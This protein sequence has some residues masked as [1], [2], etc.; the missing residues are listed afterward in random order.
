MSQARKQIRLNAFDM[1]CVGHISHGMWT[2]PRDRSAHYTDI[3]YWQHLART[4]ER[5]LFDGLFIADIIGLYDVYKG[6]PETA[7][8]TGAQ[9]PLNDPILL[10]PIMAAVTEHLGFG[11][12]VNLTYEQPYLFARRFS[13]LDHLTRG[14][15]GWNIVTGY[16]DSAARGL[17]QDKLQNHDGRYD[18]ADEFMEVVYKLWEGSWEDDAVLRDRERRIFTDPSKV[19]RISHRGPHY[20]VD[21]I[22]LSEPSPQRTPLLYQAGSSDRGRRFAGEHA[23]CVFVNGPSRAITRSVVEDIR[24]KAVAAGRRPEDVKAFVGVTVIVAPT[25][26]EAQDLF[27]EYREHAS[28]EGGLAHFSASVGLDFAAYDPDEPISF[29]KNDAN[30]SAL[31]AITKRS[32]DK[33]WTVRALREQMKLGSRNQPIVGSPSQVADQLAAWVEEADVDGFN[34]TRTVTPESVEAFVDLVVPELQDRGLYKTA[35][36]EGPLRQKLFGAPRLPD[37][38]RAAQ[39]RRSW[40][41]AAE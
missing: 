39:F 32:P 4:L 29:V 30:N 22:H 8:I 15:I 37:R 34:L 21:G 41:A 20:Q 40:P 9:T 28:T 16:L 31:E 11:I 14:R 24:R 12:T 36:E 5:G 17:G 27:A 33:V 2:H 38:H 35:Y 18:V 3:A 23:E 26:A 13:T 10:A 19:H 7:L 6:G 1:N 25:E